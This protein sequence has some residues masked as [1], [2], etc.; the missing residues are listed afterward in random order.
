MT[1]TSETLTSQATTASRPQ[2]AASSTG[3]VYA[4]V[5]AGLA[6]IVTVVGSSMANAIY[7]PDLAGDAVG[8]TEKLGERTGPLLLFHTA[9]MLA[10]LLVVVFAA[11]LR[12]HLAQRMPE[13]S[14]TPQVAGTGLVLVAVTLLMGSALD[15]EFIFVVQDPALL[16]PETAVFYGHWVATVPWVWAGAGLAALAVAHAGRRFGAVQGW[17][18]WVSLVLGGLTTLLAVSPLQ[19]M[20]GT[21]G[22]L[23]LTVTAFG[24]LRR[25]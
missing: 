2:G 13:G 25:A 14:L 10:A 16:V 6:G 1:S 20:A 22:P 15:T 5:G 17:L 19:Y 18:T 4:G 21:T 3:W 7:D 24:L 9:A 23:W 12:R 8:L 11:G